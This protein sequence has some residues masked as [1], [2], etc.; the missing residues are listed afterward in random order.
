MK[1][2]ISPKAEKQL[3]KLN[4]IEQVAIISKIRSLPQVKNKK[5]Q[6]YADIYRIRVSDF[7]IVYKQTKSEI[8]IILIAHRREVYEM[9]HRFI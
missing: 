4:K 9:L 3:R 6:G 2:T 5:L 8:Y 7:R 1:I